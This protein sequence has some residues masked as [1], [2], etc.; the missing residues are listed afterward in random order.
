MHLVCYLYPYYSCLC[1]FLP[2]HPYLVVQF[3]LLFILVLKLV[4]DIIRISSVLVTYRCLIESL[5]QLQPQLPLPGAVGPAPTLSERQSPPLEDVPLIM[6]SISNK[7]RKAQSSV[8]Y[9]NAPVSYK[10]NVRAISR[11]Q[12]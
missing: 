9:K 6:S 5:P 8:L 3:Q 1:T 10:R 2:C 12:T 4:D 11:S 7:P